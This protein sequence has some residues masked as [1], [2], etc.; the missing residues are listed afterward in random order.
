MIRA[1]LIGA[2]LVCVSVPL[3]GQAANEGP[4]HVVRAFHVAL[5]RGDSS[6]A[7]ALLAPDVVI[8]DQVASKRRVTSTAPIIWRPTY[9]SQ[10][11]LPGK[12]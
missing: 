12:S 7:L 8:Y 6:A 5:S 1:I 11:R 3:A 10:R 4:E 9:S 2:G